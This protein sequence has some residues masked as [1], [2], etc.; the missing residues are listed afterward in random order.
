M[1]WGSKAEVLEPE[2]L[3]EEIRTEVARMLKG[4]EKEVGERDMA[5][6]A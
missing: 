1:T 6:K 5:L 3:R 2:S 4:Y